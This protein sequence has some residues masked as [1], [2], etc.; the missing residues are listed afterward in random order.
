MLDN[1]GRRIKLTWGELVI[2]GFPLAVL[3]LLVAALVFLN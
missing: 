1:E 2:L 3:L